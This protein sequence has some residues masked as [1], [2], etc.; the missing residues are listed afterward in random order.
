[1]LAGFD[2]SLPGRANR[3]PPTG[4]I[5]SFSETD[6]GSPF[7]KKNGE[8]VHPLCREDVRMRI[9]TPRQK[10]GPTRPPAHAFKTSTTR[11]NRISPRGGFVRANALARVAA[12]GSLERFPPDDFKSF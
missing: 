4:A 6:A 10:A 7:F 5:L 9:D 2:P 8:E 12:V 1:L 11:A 3:A